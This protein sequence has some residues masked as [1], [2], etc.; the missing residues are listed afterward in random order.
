M[1]H[2]KAVKITTYIAGVF[3]LIASVA[4]ASLMLMS[5]IGIFYPRKIKLVMITPDRSKVYDESAIFCDEPQITYGNL[6]LGD[7][8]VISSRPSYSLVGEYE[9]RCDYMIIDRAGADVTEDYDVVENF[10]TI[11]LLPRHISLFSPTKT[12][13][14][15]GVTLYADQITLSPGSQPLLHG[16][17]LIS[18]VTASLTEPGVLQIPNDFAIVDRNGN[19]V[20]DQYDI[21]NQIG[22]ILVRAIPITVTT[23]SSAR[24]YNGEP[25]SNEHWSL[26]S[27]FPG[28][29]SSVS[30]LLPGHTVHGAC[31][32]S[33]T[34]AGTYAN[35][36]DFYVFDE[37]GADVSHLYNITILPGTLTIAPINIYIST[38]GM[39]KIYDGTPLTHPKW[40]LFGGQLLDGDV[41]SLSHAPTIEAPGTIANNMLFSV[42]DAKGNDVTSCYKISQTTGNLTLYAKTLHIRTGSAS[43]IYDGKPLVCEE[44]E[45]VSGELC[46]G[47]TISLSFA[48][49]KTL[50]ASD[51]FVLDCKIFATNEDGSQRDVTACY[52]VTYDYGTLL[53]TFPKEEVT[54]G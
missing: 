19:N 15:D 39:S 4:V 29:E 25:L 17:T 36:G 40:K 16:H 1:K 18:T 14:Y 31:T 27:E 6:R 10:G 22:S 37:S 3:I 12:K 11:S 46:E 13:Y 8:L 44:F 26:Y 33:V 34:K 47:E 42:T 43:K 32:T 5:A 45:I 49:L 51:N 53:V 20:T 48:S 2:R 38:E 41:L 35:M 23:G 54:N 9:N 7:K 52:H 50:G 30:P 21:E 24:S 28:F